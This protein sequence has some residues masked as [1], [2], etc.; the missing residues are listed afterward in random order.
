MSCWQDEIHLLGDYLKIALLN[1]VIIAAKIFLES[2]EFSEITDVNDEI[3]INHSC[4][5]ASW[6]NISAILLGVKNTF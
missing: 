6:E 1:M 4:Y 3:H 2:W 5:A